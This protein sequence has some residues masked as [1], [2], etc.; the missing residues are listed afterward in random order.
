MAHFPAT[1]GRNPRGT[2]P[3]PLRGTILYHKKSKKN[4]HVKKN[5]YICTVK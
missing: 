2:T 1:P 3:M 4:L 5:V